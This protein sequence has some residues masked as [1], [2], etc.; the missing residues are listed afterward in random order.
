MSKSLSFDGRFHC[1]VHPDTSLARIEGVEPLICVVCE[2]A[3]MRAALAGGTQVP[4]S[5]AMRL[6]PNCP[7]CGGADW[8]RSAMTERYAMFA[9][10]I[11]RG[12]R[13]SLVS[14]VA[15][16]GESGWVLV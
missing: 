2:T 1:P 5:D 14:L 11:C 6:A 16:A 10:L 13:L 7:Q 12:C 4:Q 15:T 3:G 8:L 9:I